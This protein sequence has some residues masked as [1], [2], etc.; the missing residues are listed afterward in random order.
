MACM[1]GDTYCWSCGPAQGNSKCNICGKWGS[2]E[3]EAKGREEDRLDHL[4]QLYAEQETEWAAT[5]INP[6]CT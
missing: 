6:S 3:C 4:D 1:C 5:H 2:A